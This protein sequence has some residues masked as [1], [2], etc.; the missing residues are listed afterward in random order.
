M[1]SV[2]RRCFP[3][4]SRFS[5]SF[6]RTQLID[7]RLRSHSLSA[8][9]AVSIIIS[10]FRLLFCHSSAK[11]LLFPPP[12]RPWLLRSLFLV[13]QEAS[14]PR[15]LRRI[16]PQKRIAFLGEPFFDKAAAAT[17]FSQSLRGNIS[18]LPRFPR[19]YCR[20]AYETNYNRK[21]CSVNRLDGFA[22][23]YFAYR[24]RANDYCVCKMINR[25]QYTFHSMV[26]WTS[27]FVRSAKHC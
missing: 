26:I 17:E 25:F 23:R 21:E 19:N 24:W 5:L 20:C 15:R 16:S 8:S 2:E 27:N 4:F 6:R 13:P 7:M 18:L 12:V 9:T 3:H 14:T 1:Y 22:L 11:L 10:S